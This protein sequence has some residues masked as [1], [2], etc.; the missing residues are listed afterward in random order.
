MFVDPG[1]CSDGALRL[2]GGTVELQG[3]PEVE[4]GVAFVIV[5]GL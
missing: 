2:V 5:D 1:N 3:R 4:C